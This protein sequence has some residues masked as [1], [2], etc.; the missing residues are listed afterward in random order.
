MKEGGLMRSPDVIIEDFVPRNQRSEKL[1]GAEYTCVHKAYK[2]L[3]TP[4]ASYLA[5][6]V[7]RK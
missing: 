6:R 7:Y 4:S 2:L 1:Q 3:Y 5:K